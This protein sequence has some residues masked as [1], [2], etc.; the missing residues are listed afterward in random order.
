MLQWIFGE[1][2]NENLNLCTIKSP[3][4]GR[5]TS[6]KGNS[7]HALEMCE[8]VNKELANQNQKQNENQFSYDNILNSLNMKV[9]DG[10]LE[11]VDSQNSI[12]KSKN[13]I[14]NH[15]FQSQD[16]THYFRQTQPQQQ[17]QQT[18]QFV[19]KEEFQKRMAYYHWQRYQAKKR[20]EQIKSKKML[21]PT[22]HIQISREKIKTLSFG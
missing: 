14:I 8:G 15:Y 3:T 18:Q 5:F 16:N 13:K 2:N 7:Y 19:T 4:N 17:P 1:E 12:E 20:I 22:N 21:Y 6:D 10:K 9:R 11:Y